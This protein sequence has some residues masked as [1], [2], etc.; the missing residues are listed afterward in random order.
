[1]AQN[2]YEQLMQGANMLVNSVGTLTSSIGSAKLNKRNRKF[3]AEQQQKLMDYNAAENEKAY[4]RNLDMW[5]KVNAYNA[6]AS[7]VQRLIDAGLNPNLAYGNISTGNAE[8]APQAQPN[9][10]VSI[11]Q[12]GYSDYY[13]PLMAGF[14][15]MAQN[16][17]A[18]ATS[19]KTMTENKKVGEEYTKLSIE[20]SVLPQQLSENL[21]LTISQRGVSDQTKEN[22]TVQ[23]NVLNRNVLEM[24]ERVQNWKLVNKQKGF[25]VEITEIQRDI[26]KALKDVRIDKGKLDKD[27]LQ[28]Q[29]NFM[30]KHF[31]MLL[32]KESYDLKMLFNDLYQSDFYHKALK[33]RESI[34][35]QAVQLGIESEAFEQYM[36]ERLSYYGHKSVDV[37]GARNAQF[38]MSMLGIIMFYLEKLDPMINAAES[39]VEM[40]GTL[41]GK[42]KPS[43][44]TNM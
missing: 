30:M 13:Q 37:V 27:V 43:A 39:G 12:A 32:K 18:L 29:Y 23:Y 14:K 11:D 22:L 1:M 21:L 42:K 20:N 44:Q 26:E 7:Q 36:R 34:L 4:Q 10:G 24:D 40:Y 9:Q 3:A 5:N 28:A 6:P 31:P 17:L 15:D 16:S 19:A 33:S 2:Q 41:K 38:D 35:F 8:S 25:E